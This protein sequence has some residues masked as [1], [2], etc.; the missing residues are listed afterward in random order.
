MNRPDLDLELTEAQ[1][2]QR[3]VS[4]MATTAGGTF[5]DGS[6]IED[7]AKEAAPAYWQDVCCRLDGPEACAEADIDCWEHAG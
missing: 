3:F 6:S 1:F 7:Y 5:S 2:V 4:H